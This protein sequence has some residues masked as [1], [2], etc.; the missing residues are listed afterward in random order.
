MRIL[1]HIPL[2]LIQNPI[3]SMTDVAPERP[4][5]PEH[6]LVPSVTPFS[7]FGIRMLDFSIRKVVIL[8]GYWAGIFS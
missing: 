4:S 1:L 2:Q 7:R 6:S 8:C 5:V 3:D